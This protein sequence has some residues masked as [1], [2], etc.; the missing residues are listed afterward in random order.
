MAGEA[1][2]KTHANPRKLKAARVQQSQLR[3][4]L[5]NLIKGGENLERLIE[6][7]YWSRELGAIDIARA[8][9]TMPESSSDA[10]RAF[11]GLT[12]DP[13]SIVAKLDKNG[14]LSMTVAS[15]AQVSAMAD[16]MAA[17][18]DGAEPPYP[19]LTTGKF[20]GGKRKLAA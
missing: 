6:L 8:F 1:V 12:P 17:G 5:I 13:G 14:C 4:V 20:R 9:V 19:L 15:V 7:Y 11:M 18:N 2:M 3:K 10:V 16:Y